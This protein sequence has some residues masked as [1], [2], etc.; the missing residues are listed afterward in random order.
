[1]LIYT[2]N[3]NTQEGE[4][5]SFQILAYFGLYNNFQDNMDYTERQCQNQNNGNG[6]L[7]RWISKCWACWASIK[8]L[9][10]SLESMYK[11]QVWWH[12]LVIPVLGKQRLED[13]W[14]SLARPPSP[15]RE[16]RSSWEIPFSK[17]RQNVVFCS[18]HIGT[19]HIHGQ[20]SPTQ[21]QQRIT[22]ILQSFVRNCPGIFQ[23]GCVVFYYTSDEQIGENPHC[24]HPRQHLVSLVFGCWLFWEVCGVIS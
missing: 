22:T 23:T 8:S 15:G 13:L 7:G 14:S 11:S 19:G 24:L 1:M 6:K 12:T 18:P 9:V 2:C 4:S 17:R 16:P 5:G 21:L 3:P 10:S 20:P